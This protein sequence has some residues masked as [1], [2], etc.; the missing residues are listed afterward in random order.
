MSVIIIYSRRIG[1][2]KMNKKGQAL[3][4]FVLILPVFLMILFIIIDFATIFSG[5]NEL[6]SNASSVIE[7][8]QNG[9]TTEEIL[10][11]YRKKDNNFMIQLEPKDKYMNVIISDYVDLITPG[12][13][14]ILEDPYP[15][16]IER[17]IYYENES[18]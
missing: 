11:I 1:D 9:S 3:I 10:Q 14:R 18:S 8:L 16:K 6:E 5:K 2:T 12:L 4:E 7:M 15:I 13:N 17:V